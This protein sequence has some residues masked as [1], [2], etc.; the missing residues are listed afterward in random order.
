MA[1]LTN[2]P[3]QSL[4]K[5]T[6]EQS[7]DSTQTTNI[8]LSVVLD[9]TIAET[10]YFSILDVD[11]YEIISAT[12]QDANGEL[13]GVTRGLPLASGGSSSAASHGSGVT[14]V[15]SNPYNIFEDI[16]TAINA[17]V[18][19]SGDTIT[20]LIGFSGS[21][22]IQN[23]VFADATA[24]D[25]AITSPINGLIVYNTAQGEFQAYQSG[26]WSNV[27]SGSTQPNASE[28]VAGKVELATQAEVDAGTP[29]GGTGASLVVT[30]DKLANGI[31][32][33]TYAYAETTGSGSAYIL[34]LTPAITSLAEGQ[35]FMAKANHT[36]TGA[37]TMDISGLGTVAIQ[38]PTGGALVA[39]NIQADDIYVFHYD[40]TDLQILN[41]NLTPNKGDINIGSGSGNSVIL[42]AGA[43]GTTLVFD[44][45]ETSGVKVSYQNQSLDQDYSGTI[46]TGT[47]TETT[48]LTVSVLGNTLRG[49][50]IRSRLFCDDFG[51]A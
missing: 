11:N 1:D 31:Q 30:P 36:N 24:R 12:G 32:N 28:T 44:S 22:R 26:A 39:G 18:D 34:T 15:L 27:S 51:D 3:K 10:V 21:G 48:V 49:K 23:P 45:G 38:K 19:T 25:A 41:P 17:K 9:Y 20:G 33:S 5:T 46:V 16:Q 14:V 37:S 8:I 43:D 47:T 4:F 35:K 13:T 6:L 40:G 50:A 7:V 2:I 42:P 29:T